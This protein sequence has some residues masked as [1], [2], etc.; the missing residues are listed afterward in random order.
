MAEEQNFSNHAKFVPT[1][2]AFVVPVLI[3]N[4]IWSVVRL[5][6][7]G[8]TWNGLVQALTALALVFL[9]FHARL[10]ALKVQDRII[11]M[12]ER[13]RFARLL[14]DDLKPRIGEFTPGQ[15]I[16]LRFAG[17]DELPALAR[18]VLNNKLTDV[19]A[20]KQ[21]VQHWRADYLRA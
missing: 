8:F 19:K 13:Q 10:F 3:L 11:R 5:V 20:I 18:K 15:L 17:D 4:L 9:S 1:Y 2:H 21:M 14:P 6:R 16:A 12:E 7:P